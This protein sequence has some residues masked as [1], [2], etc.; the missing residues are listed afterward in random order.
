MII[1]YQHFDLLDK[2]VLEYV[3]FD[4]PLRT[5]K[6]MHDEACFI[7]AVQGASTVYGG[8]EKH[9]L[10]TDEGMLMKCGNYVN[11]WQQTRETR[12]Y[13]AVVV[14]FYPDVLRFVYQNEVPSFLTR[15]ARPGNKLIH[16]ITSEAAIESYIR[17]LLFYF[18][19]PTL[20]NEEL[21]VLKVKE[22]VLLLYNTD[23]HSIRDMLHDLFNPSQIAFKQIITSRLLDN[24]SLEDFAQ[25]THLSLSSF[26]RKFKDTFGESPA[27]YL[28][29]ARLEHAAQRLR[30]SSDRI[31]DIGY[32][33]GFNDVA[34]FSKSFAAQY[35]RSPSEY[36]RAKLT[37]INK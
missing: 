29:K 35:G 20:A 21:V 25:L 36:R 5:D 15:Q 19:N 4:P 32:D 22:L 2:V 34:H 24:L 16:K 10:Q 9:H 3:I 33:C 18:N 27:R 12:P 26:K 14:H 17:S 6:M 30:V 13:E 28:K 8:T 1:K 23:S 37:Q 7:Y 31:S 11:N